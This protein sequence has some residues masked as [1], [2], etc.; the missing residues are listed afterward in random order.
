MKTDNAFGFAAPVKPVRVVGLEAALLAL[1]NAH[2]GRSYA[3]QTSLGNDSERVA[4]ELREKGAAAFS[5]LVEIVVV[6][7]SGGHFHIPLPTLIRGKLVANLVDFAILEVE[8]AIE[9]HECA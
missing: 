4:R 8:R 7:S 1:S 9:P 2:P 6:R 5:S 3:L